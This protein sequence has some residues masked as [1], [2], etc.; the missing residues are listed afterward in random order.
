MLTITVSLFIITLIIGVPIAFVLGFSPL[1]AIMIKNDPAMY[2]IVA[3]RLY[4]GM[5]QFPIMAV[6]FFVLAGELMSS[7]KITKNL[8]NLSISLVGHF[9]GALAQVNILVS[10][11]FAGLTG[12]AVADTVAIGS[13]L[14]PAMKKDGYDTKFSTA[15][16]AASSVIGPIIPPSI[17]MII[18]A[19]AMNVSVGA[20]FLGGI[21][22]G[23]VIGISLMIFVNFISRK[24]NY[25][26]REERASLKEIGIN[27][28]L[29]IPAFGVPI[30]ILGGILGGVCTPT[31]AA[32]LAD[33][34]AILIGV[35]ILRTIKFKDIPQIFLRAAVS[36]SIVLLIIGTSFIFG[37]VAATT[38]FTD[39]VSQFLKEISTNY[40]VILF[41]I[42]IFLFIVGLFIDSVPTILILAPILSP[43]AADLGMSPLHF[44]IMMCINLTVGLVTPPVGMVLFA[45]CGVSGLSMEKLAKEMIPFVLIEIGIVFLIAYIPSISLYIPKF[46]G[47][48]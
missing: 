18:Y 37:W 26:K 24:R 44:A 42:N 40:Y 14:I 46:F 38:N 13:I 15:V 16:T 9:R 5:N 47:F 43:I 7:G 28:K 25:P 1:I 17:M 2:S 41:L 36:S 12:S 45:A 31:E 22:P 21:I 27:L 23:L 3:Q 11:I 48:A 35:F 33:A 29:S 30:I 19:F 32:A 4:A 34:Y 20:M 6:P 8:I 10:I 39:L